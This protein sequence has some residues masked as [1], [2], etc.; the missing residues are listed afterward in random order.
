MRGRWGP[1][2]FLVALA[3]AA[4]GDSTSGGGA[5]DDTNK[6]GATTDDS[7]VQHARDMCDT[8]EG[9]YYHVDQECFDRYMGR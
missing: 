4:C 7:R 1:V 3:C 5:G 9:G 2:L 6:P 8:N